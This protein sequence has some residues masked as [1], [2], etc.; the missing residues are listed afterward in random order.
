M[1]EG[2]W[3]AV[4]VRREAAR[5]RLARGKVRAGVASVGTDRLLLRLRPPRP[6]P[7]PRLAPRRLLGRRLRGASPRL[8][9]RLR[10]RLLSERLV[11]LPY[12]APLL[13]RPHPTLDDAGDE[14]EEEE[15]EALDELETSVAGV[16]DG[17]DA[18]ENPF[19]SGAAAA[20]DASQQ[21]SGLTDTLKDPSLVRE[22]LKE[23]QDPAAQA[24]MRAM[25]ED[26]EFQK[27]MQQYV[28]QISKDPQFEQQRRHG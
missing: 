27:S 12:P 20:S 10:L 14:E 21:L 7:R 22:A 28:E 26:P 11:A 5:L 23:L 6:R 24:R 2:A 13:T 9:L 18:L 19:L 15:E 16:G 3:L 1:C 8:C 17:D 4:A 25:M